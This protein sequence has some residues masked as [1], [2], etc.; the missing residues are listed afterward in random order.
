VPFADGGATV[1]G[2]AGWLI[3]W[4]GRRSRPAPGRSGSRPSAA[5]PAVPSRVV[6]WRRACGSWDGKRTNQRSA[7]SVGSGVRFVRKRA[8]PLPREHAAGGTARESS[9]SPD[10]VTRIAVSIHGS[11][12]R[13]ATGADQLAPWSVE[14]ITPSRLWPAGDDCPSRCRSRGHRPACGP[15]RRRSGRRSRSC[16]PG[17]SST[18]GPGPR[19]RPSRWCGRRAHPPAGDPVGCVGVPA[20]AGMVPACQI[21]SA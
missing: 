2:S 19:W 9:N 3:S 7:V 20:V 16:W 4:S 1:R 11:P 14:R 17:S 12:T 8:Q 5:R 6:R 15:V 10:G 18:P 13:A 21:T